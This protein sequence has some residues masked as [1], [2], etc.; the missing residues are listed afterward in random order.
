M[1]ADALVVLI[2]AEATPEGTKDLF[3]VCQ[4]S[5]GWAV[6]R[7]GGWEAKRRDRAVGPA[8]PPPP[9]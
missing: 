2:D 9:V 8:E 3:T 7:V 6:E 4:V 1:G 5:S